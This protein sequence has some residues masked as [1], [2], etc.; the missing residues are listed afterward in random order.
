MS[1]ALIQAGYNAVFR[2]LLNQLR[3][4]SPTQGLALLER[5]RDDLNEQIERATQEVAEPDNV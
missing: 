1:E 4:L 3:E 5:I 2:V